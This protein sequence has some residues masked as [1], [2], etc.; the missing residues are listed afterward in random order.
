MTMGAAQTPLIRWLG[1]WQSGNFPHREGGL[2]FG[3]VGWWFCYFLH[4]F[5]GIRG[6]K[7]GLVGRVLIFGA[8]R[9]L[10][11]P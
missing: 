1:H 11:L 5:P 3:G 2:V 9:V 7:R 8:G 10:L 4:S 6:L